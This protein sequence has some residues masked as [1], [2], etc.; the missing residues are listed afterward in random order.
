ML[1]SKQKLKNS[2]GTTNGKV[3]HSV[4]DTESMKHPCDSTPKL[5]IANY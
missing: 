2:S 5:L 1:Y 4:L 3:C